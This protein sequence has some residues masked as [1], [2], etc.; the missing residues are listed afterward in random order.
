MRKIGLLLVV[1]VLA[2]WAGA[3][4]PTC[5]VTMTLDQAADELLDSALKAGGT[6]NIS[7]ILIKDDGRMRE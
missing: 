7:F 1:W 2:A 6:D 4:V 3:A 5:R